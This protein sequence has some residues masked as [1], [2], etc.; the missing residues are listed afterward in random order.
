MF[1]VVVGVS[2][3]FGSVQV[4]SHYLKFR[5]REVSLAVFSFVTMG[6]PQ[7]NGEGVFIYGYLWRAR[8]SFLLYLTYTICFSLG[9]LYRTG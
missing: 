1:I 9:F 6:S 3:R 2:L 7:A 5:Y 8:H 4:V